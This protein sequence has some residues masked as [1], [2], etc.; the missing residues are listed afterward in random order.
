MQ[1]GHAL[2]DLKNVD[3]VK[4]IAFSWLVGSRLGAVLP[5]TQPCLAK[6]GR[7][8]KAVREES[9]KEKR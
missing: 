6:P 2:G 7:G 4:F 8:K 5:E 9:K 1:C 3:N